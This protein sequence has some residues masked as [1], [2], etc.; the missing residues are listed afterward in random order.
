MYSCSIFRSS[1]NK[2][3]SNSD[4]T[5]EFPILFFNVFISVALVE[6]CAKWIVTKYVGYKNSNFD[7]IYD[8]IVYS[9][10]ASLVFACLENVL[11]V[12]QNGVIN[13]IVRSITSIPGHASFGIAMGYFFAKARVNE[14]NNNKSGKSKNMV[15][16]LIIPALLH[17]IYDAILMGE[18]S[19]VLFLTF[20][21]I[22]VVI[23]FRLVNKISK[24][25]FNISCNIPVLNNSS[26]FPINQQ[27]NSNPNFCP[28]CGTKNHN[29]HF[30]T[31][32][33]Y[34]LN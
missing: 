29:H 8:I 22:M 18:L 4:S 20:H 33:G 31:C 13:A 9:V 25:Q 12:F 30:C 1:F 7:E 26:N 3:F 27:I 24:V 15:L 19:I 14:M 34:K 2:V 28:M 6:E 21:I 11:Y 32:C 5:I 23:C 10:F 17:T 16:S